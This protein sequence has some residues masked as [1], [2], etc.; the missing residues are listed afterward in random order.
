MT[1]EHHT[2]HPKR[3]WLAGLMGDGSIDTLIVALTDMQGRLMG[4]RVQGQ[5]FLNGAIDHGAHFCTYLLGTDMEMNTPDGFEL[6]NW[7]TGYGDWIADPLWETLR[8][9]PWL[10]KTAIVLSDTVDHHGTEIPVSPR[11]ILKRQV[12]K[13]TGLG[14]TVMA[15]SEYEYYLLTDTYE[16]AFRKGFVDLERFG[17]YNEDYHLL[18]AT[19]GEP[20]HGKLRNLMTA[21]DIPV[22]FSKGEAAPGQHEVNIHYSDVLLMADR[23]V[24]FKHGAKEIAWLNGYGLTFM[25][26]PD[27]TWT[28]SSGHLHISLWDPAGEKARFFEEGADPYGMS[29]TMRHFLGGM[30]AY[31]R[32]LSIF[33]APNINS[34]KRYAVASWAPVTVVWGR[35]NRTTGFRIVGDGAGLHI[36]D[37][38]PGGDMNPYLAY[39]AVVGAG[40]LGIERELEPPAEYHGNGYVATGCD[41]M[42]RALHEAIRELE[43]SEAAVDIFGANVVAHYLNAARVE[44]ETYDAV[45]HPWDRERYLERG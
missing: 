20:I 15:G 27:H 40:L 16:Q 44:Q 23:S 10:E 12:E 38:F 1:N 30:M 41:R 35:D 22:E 45:V 17:H 21:A 25:A 43:A 5:A 28:G 18:Q 32:E 33:V 42:P 19:K 6:M 39:A 29:A 9:V 8:V 37:R 26:K 24:L 34:Y 14:F 11:T 4:K 2:S 7:E 13:A 3:D 36:E 31:A